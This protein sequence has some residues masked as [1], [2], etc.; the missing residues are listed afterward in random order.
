MARRLLLIAPSNIGDA[1][2]ASDVLALLRAQYPEAHLTVVAGT[3]AQAL[4][5]QDPRIQTLV[6]LGAYDSGLGRLRLAWAL[7]RYQPQVVVDLRHTM[8]P[9]LLKPLTAWRYLRQPPR[10]VTHMRARHLWALECQAPATAPAVR[11]WQ[12]S[13]APQAVLW[14]APKDAAQID[15]LWRRWQLEAS[16]PVVVICPGARSHI[17]RWTAEGFAQVADRLIEE[18]QAQIVFS[19]EPDEDPIVQEILGR[20]RSPAHSAVGLT[21]VRQV[22]VLMQRAQAVLTND[23]ASLHL[24]SAV[25]VPTAALFGPTDAVKYGPTAPRHA[26]LRRPLFCAPCETALCRFNHECMRFLS[27]EEVYQAVRHLL[28]GAS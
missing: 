16:R 24:A 26:L 11:A 17:K 13:A 14:H 3:R 5:Q 19:G 9:L 10:R 18:A 12:E 6:D 1:I 20:M 21:T 23:S 28:R 8:Y 22:A 7:W 25:G 4:W 27:A 2:L 15:T